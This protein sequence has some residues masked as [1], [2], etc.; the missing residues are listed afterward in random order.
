VRNL[1]DIIK[2]IDVL[3]CIGQIEKP[4][5]SI[6]FESSKAVENSLFIAIKGT[7][8]D[9]HRYIYHAIDMGATVIVCENLPGTFHENVTFIRTSNTQL[10]LGRIASAFYDYPSKKLSVIGITGTNGKTTIATLLYRLFRF[11]GQKSGLISTVRNYVDS[12]YYESTHTTPDPVQLNKLM[13]KMCEVGCKYCFMEVSSH[14]IV[15]KRI[16]AI[17]FKGGVFT[18]L[19][20]DHLDYHETF[21]NYLKAKKLFFDNLSDNAFA[22]TSLDDKNGKVMVQNTKAKVFTYG[23]ASLADYKAR[24]IESHLNGTLLNI[25]GKEVWSQLI[26]DFNALNILAV[27]SVATKLGLS[28]IECLTL[29]SELKSVEGR[30]QYQTSADGVTAIVDYAHTPDALLN[31][32]K[33]INALTGKNKVITVVGAGGNRDKTKRPIMAAT[34]ASL[35]D[36]IILTS[37]NPR[38]EDPT[39]IINEMYSGIEKSDQKKTLCISDRKEAIKTACQLAG[40]DDIILVAG[41]GHET[42]QEIKG[43]KNHF[44]DK[45]VIN[46]IFKTRE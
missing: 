12:K 1:Q 36:K 11:A 19:T 39:E 16:E 4:V 5:F 38:N 46:E 25:N 2:D 17:E 28:E 8:V 34:A 21:E 42:Y 31:V 40:K 32:L 37:D 35:S 44:D 30:F 24:I 13:A 20:H 26:G 15:Q 10:A 3:E 29:I 9:G 33:T 6:C 18:N 7:R 43:V 14:A 22:I 45:E 23:L 41:K 27:Y